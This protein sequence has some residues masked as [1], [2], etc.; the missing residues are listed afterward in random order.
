[1][2][3]KLLWLMLSLSLVCSLN[4][5]DPTPKPIDITPQVELTTNK[6]VDLGEVS[7][8]KAT[9]KNPPPNLKK[10]TLTWTVKKNGK[11]YENIITK[12]SNDKDV[13]NDD[14][15]IFGVGVNKATFEI[16]LLVS[17][18]V[19]DG[20]PDKATNVYS[21]SSVVEKIITVGKEP[22]IP[23]TPTVKIDVAKLRTKLA[24]LVASWTDKDRE[25]IRVNISRTFSML[26]HDT[27]HNLS[28]IKIGDVAKLYKTR[29]IEIF[30]ERNK[31][32]TDFFDVELLNDVLDSKDSLNE[33]KRK[34]LARY[35][36][37]SELLLEEFSGLTPPI[38][39]TPP[40]P[41]PTGFSGEV[42]DEAAKINDVTNCLALGNVLKNY[43]NSL[44]ATSD[45]NKIPDDL[46]TT[47]NS[48]NLPATWKPFGNW[49]VQQLGTK[50]TT[51][52]ET[53]TLLLDAATGLFAAGGQR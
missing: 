30:G 38:P 19:Y 50:A 51:A 43:S 3:R 1:M 24:P 4:A 13:V 2:Y 9:L 8:V 12:D 16:N 45:F 53:K 11:K 39:P 7:M 18:L 34:D 21:A 49:A 29:K 42:Y 25:S 44:V 10:A 22:I 33:T 6:E 14:S 47:I 27:M 23:P 46:A 35:F 20:T 48:L 28:L 40:V 5:Q 31:Y 26:G 32:I 37:A 17:Y 52:L 41:R 36:F 15:I